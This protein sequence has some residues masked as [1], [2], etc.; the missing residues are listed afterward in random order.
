MIPEVYTRKENPVIALGSTGGKYSKTSTS[1]VTV[2][3]N[4]RVVSIGPRTS[5][6][7]PKNR[8]FS[9]DPH[10][11]SFGYQREDIPLLAVK[12]TET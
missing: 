1:F 11:T 12:R 8:S 6:N 2:S 10:D 5:P 7:L 4:R 9:R 3:S